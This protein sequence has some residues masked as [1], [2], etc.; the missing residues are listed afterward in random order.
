[1][2]VY[3]TFLNKLPNPDL[4]KV[5]NTLYEEL[6]VFPQLKML[7][8]FNLP[9][10]YGKTWICYFNLVKKNQIELCFV[11]ARELPSKEL[12]DFKGRSMVAG[13]SYKVVDDIDLGIVKLLLEEA[14]TLD[15]QL[16]FSS[17]KRKD[18]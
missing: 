11:R 5:C 3:E 18:K 4:L 6:M 13:L 8:K 7:R 10:F 2:D 12:L 9:F 1:M 16:P 15:N 17:V 14:I